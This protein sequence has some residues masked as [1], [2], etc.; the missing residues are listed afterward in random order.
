M[1][2]THPYLEH[3]SPIAFA[4]RGG[5][6][7]AAENTMS[8][9][10]YAVD[11]GYRY[12]ET[13]VHLSADGVL[14]AFHDDDLSRICGIDGAISELQ[15]GQ[16][17]SIRLEGGEHIPRFDELL[18][19]W[20]KLKI[21]IEPKSDAAVDPLIQ[22]ISA[23][24][25][26]E[27]VCVGSFQD[28]RIKRCRKAFG[29]DLCTS[30]GEK[31]SAAFR[32]YSYGLV[33]AEHIEANCAQLPVKFGAIPLVDKRLVQAADALGIG[34]HVWTVNDVEEMERLLDLG[35]SAIMTD[36]VTDLRELLI[37]RNEWRCRNA[38]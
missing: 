18:Y 29:A 25:V 14:Y 6:S 28:R 33:D 22:A 11:L 32:A 34:I 1:S 20:P 24:S 2:R 15:S 8:A 27:R 9:F 23:P 31:E 30:M 3:S 4:H 7:V 21:N 35:V 37:K 26:L 10:Q 13:D 36:D 17:D 38:A 5:T 19:T 16:V 12:V